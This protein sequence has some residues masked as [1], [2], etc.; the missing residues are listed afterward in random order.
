MRVLSR[1]LL[2]ALVTL[3]LVLAGL[4]SLGVVTVRASFPQTDGLIQA[5]PLTRAVEVLRDAQGIPHIYADNPEDLFAAQGFVHAQDRFWEMDVRRHITSGRLSELFGESQVETDVFLRTLGMHRVA[6]QE[7][8]LLSV[9]HRRYV[10]AY[11]D[12]VNA[13]LAARS[14][15][16]LSLEYA[17][18]GLQGLSYVPKQ[19]TAVDSIAWL[20][21]MAWDVSSNLSGEIELA[22]L[23][24]SVGEQRALS[25][26]PSFDAEVFHPIVPNGAVADGAFDPALVGQNRPAP[27]SSD[28]QVTEP[29]AVAALQ[30]VARG[31]DAVTGWLAV[32]GADAIGSNSWVV[33]GERTASGKPILANDPHLAVSIPGIFTQ[34]G[35][36]CRTVT[37]DCPFDVSG[38]SF[39]GMPGVIV[40]HNA[41]IAWGLTTPYVDTQDLVIEQIRGRQVRRGQDEWGEITER[42]ELIRVAGGDDRS[43]NVRETS[44]GPLLSDVHAAMRQHVTGPDDSVGLETAV[45]LRWSALLPSRSIEAIFEFNR[46]SNFDEFRAAA[47]LLSA[48]S[49]NL[50]FADVNGNIGYQLPGA[51]PVRRQGDGTMP[52]PGWD[53]AYGWERMIPFEELP[54]AHNPPEGFVVAANQ[55]IIEDYPLPL[56]SHYSRGWRSQE[57]V[58]ILNEQTEPL[59]VASSSEIFNDTTVRFAELIVPYLLA[60]E[61]RED[62]VRDGQEVLRAWDRQSGTD[63]TGAFYFHLVMK[64]IVQLAFDDEVPPEVRTGSTDRWYAVVA[65]LLREPNNEWWDDKSTTI[66]EDR[67]AIL[68]RALSHARRDATV[69]RSLD[70]QGWNWGHTHRLRLRHQTLGRSGIGAVES[71]F[72]RG[73]EPVGGGTAVVLA[74]SFNDREWGF[75]VTNGPAMKMVVDLADLDNSRWINL[76]G[77]SGHAFHPNYADQLSPM[78]HNQLRPWRFSRY[79]VEEGTTQRLELLPGR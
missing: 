22:A 77:Q 56:G 2:V 15:N 67:D 49:Q 62:W 29:D 39:A 58:D 64:H 24:A 19:W 12:G 71:L 25:V 46:A 79:R 75:E 26:Q 43:I 21:A 36:H 38:F 76:S 69:L 57:I 41:H 70:P 17:I 34:V 63:S 68:D 48:P 18:L 65:D 50:I 6:E 10:E 74:W 37:A 51:I 13:Y 27:L 20:K 44:N 23:T 53:P 45:A 55:Q 60:V 31:Q 59:T 66:V 9:R 7:L 14:A 35:L 3:V 52:V 54:F 28:P 40:G 42:V 73:D 11:A 32:G 30:S 16:E 78:A 1:A 8:A 61:P 72:N 4:L 47:R 5:P 33:S